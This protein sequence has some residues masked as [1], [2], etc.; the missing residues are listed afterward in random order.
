MGF[1]V[2]ASDLDT[3][4][5]AYMPG[6]SGLTTADYNADMGSGTSKIRRWQ[7][8]RSTSH[9]KRGWFSDACNWV[10]DH[11]VKPVVKAVE[12]VANKAVDAV[13][14]AAKKAEEW[15]HEAV[16]LMKEAAQLLLPTF[17]PS[18]SFTIPI[19]IE[20]PAWM[21]DDSPW[22]D[23]YKIYQYTMDGGDV[24]YGITADSLAKLTGAD[25]LI[26]I[27]INGVEEKPEPGVQVYCVDCS[28]TGSLKT[29]GSATYTLAIGFT[30]LQVS[31][32]GDVHAQ[33]QLGVNA[34]AEY[35][36]DIKEVRILE[37]GIPGFFIPDVI[38]VGPMLTLGVDAEIKIE[39][40]GQLLAGARYDFN[41]IG[42]TID[43][44]DHSKSS[45]HGTLPQVSTVFEAAGEVNLTASVG[46]PLGIGLGIDVLDG[47]WSKEVAIIDRPA[48][49]AVTTFNF[50]EDIAT[51]CNESGTACNS[52]TDISVNDGTCNGIAWYVDFVNEVT[53]D[54]LDTKYDIGT[55]HGPKLV[56]GCVGHV[57]KSSNTT[58]PTTS[59]P[60][61]G[62][63][64]IN[65]GGASS[66][67]DLSPHGCPLQDNA[68]QNSGFELGG[69]YPTGWTLFDYQNVVTDWGTSVDSAATS[70]P[71]SL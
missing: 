36:W 69:K 17:N 23:A 10:D 30:D 5:A 13:E 50:S 21:L 27:E 16:D 60:A 70:P 9:T 57:P 15:A 19:D 12:Y 65:T 14:Y 58:G 20:A 55:W 71:L 3:A 45:S 25:E 2:D 52:T 28:I 47:A 48:L 29:R 40:L 44:F 26:K 24:N 43:F 68:V 63:T 11:I 8:K 61:T 4:L 22:G 6:V 18:I 67:S 41:H 59:S 46:V 54:L 31:F 33:F 1:I 39:A 35:T 51:N 42:A 53:L 49:E 7:H 34:Y 56:E 32:N 38:V 64:P 62:I 37:V 66:G